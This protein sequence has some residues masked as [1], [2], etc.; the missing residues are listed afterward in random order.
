MGNLRVKKRKSGQFE[1]EKLLWEG[2]LAYSS[3]Q[4]NVY[5]IKLFYWL[6]FCVDHYSLF[7]LYLDCILSQISQMRVRLEEKRVEHL[8]EGTQFQKMEKDFDVNTE[9]E[10]CSCFYDLH[11][12]AA[13]CNCSLDKFTCIKHANLVTCCDPENRIVLLRYTIVELKT[14]VEALE[15]NPQALKVWATEDHGGDLGPKNLSDSILE[16]HNKLFG[17]D[18]LY[19]SAPS[20]SSMKN[21]WVED[22]V[23]KLSWADSDPERRANF[24]VEVVNLG[25]VV[26]GKL[27]SNK[28]AIFPKGKYVHARFSY[29]NNLSRIICLEANHVELFYR[30]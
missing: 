9:R 6:L 4:G 12:S 10:C 7:L 14:L 19:P 22:S 18:L 21:E 1:M 29:K 20:V 3:N 30:L 2:W 24:C 28:D 16:A 27:W 15:E 25:S 17:V 5:I 13:R 8:P 23:C 26:H 11:F